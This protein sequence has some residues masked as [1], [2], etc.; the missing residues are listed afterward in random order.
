MTYNFKHIKSTIEPT[1]YIIINYIVIGQHPND[2][3]G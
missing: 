1:I 3:F 2:Q